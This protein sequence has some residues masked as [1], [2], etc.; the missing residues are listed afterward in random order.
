MKFAN[1]LVAAGRH[2]SGYC[3]FSIDTK[4]LPGLSEMADLAIFD[5]ETGLLVYR[6][7]NSSN[8]QKKLLRLETHL[9]PLWTLDKVLDP[10]FQYYSKGIENLGR[11]TV[12]QL[13]LLNQVNS[14]YLSGRILYRTYA[15]YIEAGFETILLIQNPYEELAERLLV[16]GNI[17]R[18]GAFHLGFRDSVEMRATIGYAEALLAEDRSKQDDKNFLRALRQMPP[19]SQQRLL[20]HSCDC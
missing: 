6:R 10:R 9:F 1:S 18:L 12:T 7:P 3:G 16:L 8:I 14:V 19:T 13:F 17:N 11:E 20:A 2:D 4:L 5:A 15:S